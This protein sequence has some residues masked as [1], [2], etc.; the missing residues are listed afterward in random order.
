M[1]TSGRKGFPRDYIEWIKTLPNVLQICYSSCNQENT[2]REIDWFMSGEGGFQMEDFRTFD[3]HP[4]TDFN[5]IMILF[6]RRKVVLFPVGGLAFGKST[7]GRKL[8]GSFPE[9]TV[10]TITRDDIF[11]GYKQDGLSLKQARMKTKDHIENSLVQSRKPVVYFDTSN[12]F[13]SGRDYF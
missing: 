4:C 8:E 13:K 6:R 5:T 7:F 2:F 11:F 12:R 1:I 10:E 3:I 9:D